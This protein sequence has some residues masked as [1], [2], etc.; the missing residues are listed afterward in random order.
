MLHSS[1]YDNGSSFARK[2]VLVVGFGNSAGEIAIDLHEHG[3]RVSM[4]VRNAV[5]IVPRDIFGLSTHVISVMMSRLPTEVA[6]ALSSNLRNFVVGD[7]SPFGLKKAVLGPMTM[8]KKENR[9][10]L[11]DIGTIDL[12][13]K[14]EIKIYPGIEGF[15][16]SEVTFTN[17]SK[18]SFDAVILAT[19][20]TTNLSSFLPDAGMVTDGRGQIAGGGKESALP[21]L[22]FCGLHNAPA[23]LLRQIGIEAKRIAKSIKKKHASIPYTIPQMESVPIKK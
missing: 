18:Q 3:A 2:N 11:L 19:G 7:V 1:S 9:V 6:D 15:D 21:G 4:A 8:I 22:F 14:G 17:G 5:N 16:K 20:F 10:P 12:I 23:G 13:K